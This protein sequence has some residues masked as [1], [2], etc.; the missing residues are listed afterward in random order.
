MQQLI[1]YELWLFMQKSSCLK[2][3]GEDSYEEK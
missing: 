1:L 3:S 2:Q